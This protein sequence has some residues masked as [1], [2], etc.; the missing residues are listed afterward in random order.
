MASESEGDPEEGFTEE[1]TL[2]EREQINRSRAN[3]SDN[4]HQ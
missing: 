1:A 3:V 2:S 4:T